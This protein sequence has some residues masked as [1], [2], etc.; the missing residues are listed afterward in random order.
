[1]IKWIEHILHIKISGRR[2]REDILCALTITLVYLIWGRMGISC[3]ILFLTG[4][5]CAGCGMSRALLAMLRLDFQTAF[6]YHPLFWLPIPAAFL[7]LF[8]NRIPR[9]L[10]RG[11]AAVIIAAFLGV[12]VIR[13]F[14]LQDS[15]VV[16]RPEDGLI[17]RAVLFLKEREF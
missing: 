14:F 11:L 6:Y 5:S 3:P 15:I 8:R 12:Y 16:F 2:M 10:L 9:R 17:W 13:L 1:M 4:V 7:F